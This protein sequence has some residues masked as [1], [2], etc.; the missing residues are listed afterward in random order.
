[1]TPADSGGAPGGG[2]AAGWWAFPDAC[3]LALWDL[4]RLGVGQ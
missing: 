1:V 3:G 4:S 2:R